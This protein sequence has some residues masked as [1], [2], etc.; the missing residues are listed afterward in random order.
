MA[1]NVR[2][3][4]A[5][6]LAAAETLPEGGRGR[7]HRLDQRRA[8]PGARDDCGRH[9][10]GC[11]RRARTGLARDL[12]DRKIT[13][14]VVQPGPVDTAMNPA[15]GPFSALLAPRTALQR[16][17]TPEEIAAS[18]AFLLSPAASYVTGASHTVHGGL[19]I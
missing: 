11:G 5:T 6:V 2:A 18:V 15:D 12:A 4:L 16:Y 19:T 3:P 9:E 10:Q 14:N 7:G 8:G 13:V 17:A 1:I